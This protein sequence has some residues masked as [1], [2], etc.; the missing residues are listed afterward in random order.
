M[1][2]SDA[3]PSNRPTDAIMGHTAAIRALRAQINRLATFDT[4]DN[5]HVPTLLLHGETG[6]GKGLVA[7]VTHDSGPRAHGPFIDVNCAAIPETLLEAELFGFEAGAFTDAK[8]AKPGLFEAASGGTLFLDEIDSL[9]PVLQG[10]LLT[11]IEQK[12]V[13]RLGALSDRQVDVKLIAATKEDLDRYVTAGRFRADLY[14]RL[15]V[16]VLTLPPLRQRGEDV[17]RL[18]EHFLRQYARAHVMPPKQLSAQTEPWLQGYAWPGNVRELS[19]LMERVTLLCPET[20]LDASSLERFC[21]LH[22]V[23]ELEREPCDDE[24]DAPPEEAEQIR[25]ALARTGGNV[26]QA[27]RLLGLNRNTLRYRMRHYRIERPRLEDVALPAV[28]AP[29]PAAVPGTTSHEAQTESAATREAYAEQVSNWEQKPVAVLAIDLTFPRLVDRTDLPY[30]I[31]TLTAR[32]EQRLAE[33]I[34]SFGGVC[35]QHSPSLCLAVFGVPRALEQMPQ[36]AVHA[37]LA[38]QSLILETRPIDEREPAPAIRLAVHLGVVMT[39]VRAN[40]PGAL[41]LPVGETLAVPVRLL[42]HARAGE[43]LVSSQVA[44]LIED[45]CELQLRETPHQGEPSDRVEAYCVLGLKPW[46]LRSNRVVREYPLSPF[47]G[48]EREMTALHEWL[49][50]AASGQGQVLGIIGEPGIGKSRLLF[51]FRDSLKAQPSTYLEGRCLSY[52][53]IVPYLPVLDLLRQHC[54]IVETDSPETIS[55]KVHQTL[56]E[57]DLAPEEWEPYLVQLL[58]VRAQAQGLD[59]LSPEA[60]RR[61]TFTALRQLILASSQRR[62]LILAIEDVQWIDKTSEDFFASLVES[63]S[64]AAVLFLT[65]YRPGYRPPWMERSY[66]TQMALQ[67]LSSHE[68]MSL[69]STILRAEQGLNPVVRDILAKA[70]GNPFFLEELVRTITAGSEETP[71]LAVPDT[72]QGVLMER[73]DRLPDASRGLLQ[74]ASVL[75]R[76]VSLKLLKTLWD[77]SGE[78]EDHLPMLQHL[79]FLYEHIGADEPLYLFKHALTQEVAYGNVLSSRRQAMHTAVGQALESFY[80]DHLDEVVDRLAYH[81]ARSAEADKAVTYLT[82]LAVKAAR[83]YAHVE[84]VAAYQEALLRVEQLPAEERDRCRVELILPLARSIFVLGRYREVLDFLLAHQPLLDQLQDPVFTSRY[85]F[86]LGLTCFVLGDRIQAAEHA[87]LAIEAA[88]QGRDDAALG[89]PYYLLAAESFASSR[90]R[91]GMTYGREAV[92]RLEGTDEIHFLG[93]THW[94]MGW[95]AALLGNFD[96]ALASQAQ[97]RVISTA[98]D[99][100]RLQCVADLATGWVNAMRGEY[101]GAIAVLQRSLDNSPDPVITAGALANLGVA[102]LEQGSPAQAIPLLEQAVEDYRQYRFRPFQGHDTAWLAEALLAD[103][104][105]EQAHRRAFEGLELNQDVSHPY[106]A[107]LTHRVLGRIALAR[108]DTATAGQYLQDALH[109]FTAMEARYDLARTHLDLAFLAHTQSNP[110]TVTT[111]LSRAYTGFKALLAP[112]WAEK[113]E[114]L[115]QEYGVRLTEVEVDE[116][117]ESPP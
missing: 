41:S 22:H 43:L 6:T 28:S 23:V 61:R 67:S 84:A 49:E 32:W 106:G 116:L 47:V 44:R 42:G 76:E 10:K 113:T 98:T 8:R 105:L 115:A 56:C 64:G 94:I 15:A 81:Y 63:L 51:E 30:E 71:H 33:K 46:N 50:Q 1:E 53:K 70:E 54:R 45:I 48:R 110:D 75:G 107:G 65:T 38:I 37:A 85:A 20:T 55:T 18:A 109:A 60:I 100:P 21:L 117:T 14:H 17:V 103:N 87:Q 62:A 95:C 24:R 35:V 5:P 111:H 74:L 13:R 73:I 91:E 102:H 83:S 93:M 90:F 101:E 19:H 88:R 97:T 52:G 108:G 114:Q 66:V 7:R 4:V 72:I 69:V 58:G 68:S 96:V 99:D 104:Q 29:T 3:A 36:R 79:E 9:P 39:D 34:H 11:A 12:R 25:Q 2:P 89:L 59:A 82:Q 80:A 77:G 31:W 26:S 40:D 86:R 92:R 78:V 16:V 57:V 27:A 112:K